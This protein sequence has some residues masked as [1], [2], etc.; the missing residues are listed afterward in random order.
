MQKTD[1]KQFKKELKIFI[2]TLLVYSPILV[3]LLIC[4]FFYFAEKYLT[5]I[6]D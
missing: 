6:Y 3:I 4:A 2:L 5:M 1:K